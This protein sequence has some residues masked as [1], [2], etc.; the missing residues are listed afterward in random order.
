MEV[1]YF[2]FFFSDGFGSF[3]RISDL[4]FFK[5]YVKFLVE[6]SKEIVKA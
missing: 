3:R 4:D 1:I 5:E 2:F 6:N